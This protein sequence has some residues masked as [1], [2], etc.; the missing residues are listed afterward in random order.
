MRD[1]FAV[2]FPELA[3]LVNTRRPDE[4]QPRNDGLYSSKL[5]M[6]G[7]SKSMLDAVDE[8]TRQPDTPT[9]VSITSSEEALLLSNGINGGGPESIGTSNHSGSHDSLQGGLSFDESPMSVPPPLV[10]AW[11]SGQL[12]SSS[13]PIRIRKRENARNTAT[14]NGSMYQ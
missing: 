5:Q 11:Q 10:F 9:A 12:A 2:E 6:D 4:R 13:C 7:L 8:P 14:G 1:E 3:G